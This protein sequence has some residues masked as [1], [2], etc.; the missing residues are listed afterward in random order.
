MT[1]TQ[2][3]PNSQ[4]KKRAPGWWYP[5][6]FV[7]FF[8]VVVSVNG[9]MMYFAFDSWSGLETEGHYLKGLAYDDNIAG[10]KAQA[11]LG[12]DV[13]LDVQTLEE[14]GVSRK[15]SYQ[16]TFL[17]HNGKPVKA[18]KAHALFWRP[19]HEGVDQDAPAQVIT[20]GVVGGVFTLEMAGQWTVRI[21]AESQGRQ[22]QFVE[23]I[24]VK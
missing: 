8:A 23:R 2:N 15:V 10:A 14:K 16:A 24:V 13:K 21:Q 4:A 17:D 19:T 18:L 12:W 7:G 3:Q 6:I 22:Y 1:Q 20:P 9:V 11:A 5:W